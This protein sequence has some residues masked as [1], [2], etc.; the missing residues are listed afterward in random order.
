MP[1]SEGAAA[2]HKRRWR[3]QSVNG[4]SARSTSRDTA[5]QRFTIEFRL[6]EHQNAVGESCSGAKP[7]MI[8]RPSPRYTLAPTAY[9]D[10]VISSSQ[11]IFGAGDENGGGRT[12]GGVVGAGWAALITS[13]PDQLRSPLIPAAA[14]RKKVPKFFPRRT[15]GTNERNERTEQTNG[16]NKRTE[17]SNMG[18]MDHGV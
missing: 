9:R 7:K 18:S 2:R 15:N 12:N 11:N 1:T 17:R 4:E 14:R 6:L 5:Y 16:T 8:S 13:G 3:R 10:S